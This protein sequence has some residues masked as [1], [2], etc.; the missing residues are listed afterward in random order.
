MALSAVV[1]A[2]VLAACGGAAPPA[3]SVLHGFLLEPSGPAFSAAGRWPVDM[4]HLPAAWDVTTGGAGAPLV[5]V[6]DTGV[7]VTP[8]LANR[9]DSESLVGGAAGSDG[10]GHGT[11]VA[12]LIAASGADGLGLAGVCWSCRI[13]SLQVA[14]EAQVTSDL[15]AKGIDRAVA[16]HA[17]VINLSLGS[18]PSAKVERDAVARAVA[19]GAVVVAA[20]GNDGSLVPDFPAAYAGVLAVGAVGKDGVVAAFS[21]RGPWVGVLAPGCGAALDNHDRVDDAVCG[22]STS[23]AFV[24]GLAALLHSVAPAATGADIVAAIQRSAHPAKGSAHGV[25]DAVKALRAIRT[26]KAGSTKRTKG[27]LLRLERRPMISGIGAVGGRLLASTGSWSSSITS[28]ELR[29]QRCTVRSKQCRTVSRSSAYLVGRAD[30]GKALR[31]V[32]RAAG[33][34]LVAVEASSHLFPIRR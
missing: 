1:A 32:V 9:V 4:M 8:D 13:L 27:P 21:S 31:V 28:I 20:A 25:V 11:R 22:T 10:A 29:W 5:A 30:R 19:S 12:G 26:I 3:D 14:T 16:R 7:H 34:D 6:V 23:A 33:E 15:V 24:S 17:T 2:L 18:R